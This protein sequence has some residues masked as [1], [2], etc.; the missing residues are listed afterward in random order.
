M[1]SPPL[2]NRE[3]AYF[4]VVG[5]GKH[6]VV[7]EK[8]GWEPTK[9]W[10]VGDKKPRGGVQQWMLWELESGHDDTQP[11]DR[12]VESLLL[13]LEMKAETIR[14]LSMDYELTIQCVGYYPASGHGIN[15]S[16]EVI[17]RAS[18]LS[19]AFDFDFYYVSDNNHDE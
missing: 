7:T 8:L 2:T 18:Q 6:E 10:S 13:T 11:L 14:Q 1:S 12:H 19:L 5:L 15:L 16:R 17:R 9:A 4:K 3:Y